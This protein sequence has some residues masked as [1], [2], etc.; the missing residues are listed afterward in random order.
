MDTVKNVSKH[1]TTV[2]RTMT[3]VVYM[4]AVAALCAL[5]WCVPFTTTV[6]GTNIYW[7][8][9][10]FD[11]VFCAISVLGSIEFLRAIDSGNDAHT[12]RISLAQRTF[13]I[14]FCAVTVPL[15]VILEITWRAGLL[16]MVCAFAIYFMCLAATSV[17]DHEKSSVKGTI[18][19]VF[20]MLYCGILSSLLAAI[21]HLEKNSMAAM[22][23]LIICTVFTDA[24]A[25]IIGTIFKRWIPLKLAPQLSPN[26]TVI[27]A[28]GGVLGGIL[29]AVVAYYIMYLCGGINTD[30]F[31]WR[32]NEVYLEFQSENIHPL[33]TYVLVGLGTAIL[34]MIGDL[35][36]S[37][38]KRECGIK[39]MG[40]ILPGHGGVLDRFDGMLYCGVLVLLAFGTIIA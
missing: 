29:G 7:G 2:M 4:V 25:Y 17:F 40:N 6:F 19:C 34:A 9:L 32:F 35:F 3:S 15:Y 21:N 18:S 28:V 26:K 37:A 27:G 12:K 16:A 38:I 13:T 24:G 5:K 14:A 30:I 1:S 23:V 10:G 39:D 22:L 36:E 33:V 31:V 11:A 20:C 8:A